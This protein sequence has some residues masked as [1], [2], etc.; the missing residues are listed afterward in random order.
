MFI[1]VEGEVVVTSVDATGTERE[2]VR[3]YTGQFFG[4]FVLL[5]DA[6]RSG[7]VLAVTVVKVRPDAT[8]L[9]PSWRTLVDAA[10]AV[11]LQVLT[12]SR[13]MHLRLMEESLSMSVSACVLQ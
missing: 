5:S 6:P 4:E 7:S 9:A 12:L 11:W 13:T 2:L 10:A 1:L 8:E 3:R